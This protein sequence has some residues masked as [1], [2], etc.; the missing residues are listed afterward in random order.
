MVKDT[1]DLQF[2]N[3]K[4]RYRDIVVN[5]VPYTWASGKNNCD[6]DGGNPLTIW[7]DRKPIYTELI[8]GNIQITPLL[9]RE[10]IENLQSL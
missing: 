4:K 6:G 1:A 3:M 10:R 7:K 5:D 8:S 2:G 9:V